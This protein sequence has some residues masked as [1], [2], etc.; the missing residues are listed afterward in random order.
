[1]NQ[2]PV[3]DSNKHPPRS[4]QYR[5]AQGLQRA[6]HRHGPDPPTGGTAK[7]PPEGQR[8][9]HRRDSETPTTGPEATHRQ[10]PRPHLY[11][12][13]SGRVSPHASSR[14]VHVRVRTG[15]DTTASAR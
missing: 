15:P 7:R 10:T 8:N 11:G 4:Y 2:M 13:P 12:K 5:P 3:A 6:D 14:T 1:M 9:A